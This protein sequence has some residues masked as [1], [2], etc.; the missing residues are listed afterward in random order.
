MNLLCALLVF[1]SITSTTPIHHRKKS[2]TL[3]GANR[4]LEHL[5]SCCL[6]S[7]CRESQ[8]SDLLSG[9]WNFAALSKETSPKIYYRVI[10]IA[11][12]CRIVHH[13]T[14]KLIS[15][16]K[17]CNLQNGHGLDINPC[18]MRRVVLE[19]QAKRWNVFPLHVL[20]VT[21]NNNNNNN[22]NNKEL[23]NVSLYQVLSQ[24]GWSPR[25]SF[26]TQQDL[27]HPASPW[28]SV[29]SASTMDHALVLGWAALRAGHKIDEWS[30]MNVL[31]QHIQKLRPYYARHLPDY[32]KDL[33]LLST[34]KTKNFI[35]HV[36]QVETDGSISKNAIRDLVWMAMH[37]VYVTAEFG[38]WSASY[39]DVAP[40]I[41][42]LNGMLPYAM[43]EEDVDMLGELL[44]C[45]NLI[46]PNDLDLADPDHLDLN[47]DEMLSNVPKGRIHLLEMQ[48]SDGSFSATNEPDHWHTTH[49]AGLAL[50][51]RPLRRLKGTLENTVTQDT[52]WNL[53]R[54]IM[55]N[56]NVEHDEM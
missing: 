24:S 48:F 43:V 36:G 21:N 52:F 20:H 15:L 53:A 8:F 35:V 30:D 37:V 2:P 40:E 25:D 49:V 1:F 56:E 39:T 29:P 46:D 54:T 14:T 33:T 19:F 4:A 22:N 28:M 34:T 51:P 47:I 9:L 42:F 7:S 31:M 26:T 50:L 23:L 6:S 32:V 38:L 45:L 18:F 13:L 17:T 41:K 16:R 44:D 12:D 10:E 3:R 55:P 27:K 5:S 11:H